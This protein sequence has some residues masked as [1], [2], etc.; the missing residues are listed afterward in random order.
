M[1]KI[2]FFLCFFSPLVGNAL[3]YHVE[4]VGPHVVHIVAIDPTKHTLSVVDAHGQSVGEVA[5]KMKALAAING[6]FFNAKFAP[7]GAFKKKG[8][9]ISPPQKNRGALGWTT[10][11]HPIFGRLATKAWPHYQNI[12]GGA[13]LLIAN[14]KKVTDMSP[15]K[16][17]KSFGKRHARTAVCTLPNNHWLWVLVDHTESSKRKMVRKFHHLKKELPKNFSIETLIAAPPMESAPS[18]GMTLKELQNFLH[19][20]GCTWALNLDGGT[21]STL[22]YE[23]HIKNNTAGLQ[24]FQSKPAQGVSTMLILK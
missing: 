20:K 2:L 14:G 15:E 11:A 9:W 24:T 3:S 23:G 6:G 22:Y 16:T 1:K 13:P 8:R 4:K 19:G 21:S 5:Q 17:S 18:L 10:M 12:L 7:V